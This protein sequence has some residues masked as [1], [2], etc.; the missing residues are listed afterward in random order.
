MLFRFAYVLSL[1]KGESVRDIQRMHKNY[2]AIVRV[3]PNKLSYANTEVW[4]DFYSELENIPFPRN[5]DMVGEFKGGRR[6]L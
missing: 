3:T 6:P 5:P 2:G 1:W 4:H